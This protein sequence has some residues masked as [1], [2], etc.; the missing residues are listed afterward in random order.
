MTKDKRQYNIHNSSGAYLRTYW[1]IS[2]KAALRQARKVWAIA[3]GDTLT[4]TAVG[5]NERAQV[6]AR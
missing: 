6:T 4:A 3:A 2:A 1:A 5:G